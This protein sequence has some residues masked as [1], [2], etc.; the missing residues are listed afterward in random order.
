VGKFRPVYRVRNKTEIFL[1]SDCKIRLVLNE[2]TICA[3]VSQG[4]L[5]NVVPTNTEASRVVDEEDF[6][7]SMREQILWKRLDVYPI[8]KPYEM[9]S[10]VFRDNYLS[11]FHPLRM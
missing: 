2:M 4:C 1:L 8:M 6:P 5:A 3:Q 11:T 9:E 10:W 7:E